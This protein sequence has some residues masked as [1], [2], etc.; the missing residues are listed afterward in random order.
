MTLVVVEQNAHA[1]LQLADRGYLLR[2]GT[3]LTSGT[4]AELAAD[5]AVKHVYLGADPV[6]DPA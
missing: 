3:V 6:A 2:A 1:A 5:P 4:S